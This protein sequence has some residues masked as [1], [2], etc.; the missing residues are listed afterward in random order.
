MNAEDNAQHYDETKPC[1]EEAD[2]SC[3]P[4]KEEHAGGQLDLVVP[5]GPS[6][7][8]GVQDVGDVRVAVTATDHAVDSLQVVRVSLCD[9][10]VP[11]HVGVT[12][13]PGVQSQVA[14]RFT[15][16]HLAR[17]RRLDGPAAPVMQLAS[18]IGDAMC[19]TKGSTHVIGGIGVHMIAWGLVSS[20][21][22]GSEDAVPVAP[23]SSTSI[24]K[25]RAFEKLLSA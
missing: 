1:L 23:L 10:R 21:S 2:E 19:P 9:R 11:V 13:L 12:A 18:G 22:V 14:C 15:E 3:M 8:Q 24:A 17:R 16:E 25:A 20:S 6:V 7:L 5:G 4:A